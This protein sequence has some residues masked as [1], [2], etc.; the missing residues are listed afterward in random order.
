MQL[1]ELQTVLSQL[2]AHDVA[3]FAISYDSVETLRAFAERNA[4]AYPLLADEGSRIIRELGMLDEDLDAHQGEFGVGVRDNQRG[5]CYPGVF[6]LDQDGVVSD[7]RF[8][9]N[10]RVRESGHDL[11]AQML[12]GGPAA[13]TSPTEAEAAL[14]EPELQIRAYL[15]SPTYWRYQRIFLHVDLTVAPGY[16]LYAPP[17]PDGY[18]ALGIEVEADSAEIGQPDLPPAQPFRVDGLDEDFWVYDGSLRLNVPIEFILDRG[19]PAVD[20][21]IRVTLEYQV[22]SATVCLP[23]ATTTL[24]LSVSP[25][26]DVD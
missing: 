6:I 23:P 4:I 21:A 3:L 17:V 22:C 8:Q 14:G 16:H 25:R 5:V 12:G 1:V 15:D 13:D 10:Y 9:R 18:T 20:R 24:E 11:L 7:R 19:A 26:P 2:L